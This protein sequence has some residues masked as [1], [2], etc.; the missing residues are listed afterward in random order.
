MTVPPNERP[1]EPDTAAP[2]AAEFDSYRAHLM[3]VAYRVTGSRADAED[4]VQEA[5]LRLTGLTGAERAAIRDRRAWLT[6]VVG[7]ICLD[8]LRSAAVRRERYVGE[9]LPEPIVTSVDG[10]DPLDAVVRDEGV[11][12]AAM[13]VL[14]TLPPEQRLAFVLH[15]AFALPFAEIAAVLGC[16]PAAARQ[17][18]SRGR[19][20]VAAADPPPRASL[21]EQRAVLERFTAALLSGDVRA[22]AELLHPDAVLIGDADGKA[23]TTRR[24]MVGA[25]RI[26]RF[27]AGLLGKYRPGA[28]SGGRPVL[29]NGDLGVHLPAEPGG[30]GYL[31][32]DAHVQTFA[33]RDGRIVAIYD[34][35]N[36]DKL[37]R[38]PLG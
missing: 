32:L 15:D 1:L 17:H 20:A 22:V 7:R 27:F 13:V 34:Q 9:W 3:S 23:R 30:D 31:D 26:V 21:D 6:T 4:A 29:V 38:L 11:R 19:R 2:D 28:F 36:P 24:V 14:D 35:A 25:E 5:W 12:M 37:A 33:I 8:R 16:S 10:A 18:A